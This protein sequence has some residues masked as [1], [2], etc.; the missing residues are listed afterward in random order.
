[1]LPVIDVLVE[2]GEI[3]GRLDVGPVEGLEVEVAGRD[4]G[5][6]GPSQRLLSWS[7]LGA[8]SSMVWARRSG[9]LGSALGEPALVSM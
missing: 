1:V 3:L 2:I 4:V 8:A 7:Y 5:P 6:V 9:S